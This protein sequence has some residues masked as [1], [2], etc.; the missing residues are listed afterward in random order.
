M[1]ARCSVVARDSEFSAKSEASN[2]DSRLITAYAA[3]VLN[4]IVV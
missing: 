2:S 1:Q 3:A 4:N